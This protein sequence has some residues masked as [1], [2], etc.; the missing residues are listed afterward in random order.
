VLVFVLVGVAGSSLLLEE[1]S[2]LRAARIEAR[3]QSILD[4]RAR[5][6]AEQIQLTE[7]KE[8]NDRER[9]RMI[10][11]SEDNTFQE[12]EVRTENG[13]FVPKEVWVYEGGRVTWRNED[14]QFNNI[15]ERNGKFRC[16]AGGCDT[17]AMDDDQTK[18]MRGDPSDTEWS[19]SLKF[20]TAGDFR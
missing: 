1:H 8:K 7:A 2:E 4:H 12:A 16:G 14:N 19:V 13:A 15:V 10:V 9:K 18:R 3:Y 20:D 11:S 6:Q 5:K 17:E